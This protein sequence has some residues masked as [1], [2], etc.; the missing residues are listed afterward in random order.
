MPTLGNSAPPVTRLYRSLLNREPD[1]A[2]LQ[3]W[4]NQL[5]G[6]A[7]REAVAQGIYDSPEHRGIQVDEYYQHYLNRASDPQGRAGG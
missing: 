4:N 6:G 5:A 1:A 3:Y 2:G 7:T